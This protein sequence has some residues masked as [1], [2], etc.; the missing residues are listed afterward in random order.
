ML[1]KYLL[2]ATLNERFYNC[3]IINKNDKTKLSNLQKRYDLIAASD[4]KFS[5]KF[6]GFPSLLERNHF[7]QLLS[8]YLKAGNNAT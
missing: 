4:L 5:H 3:G 1:Q 2:V 8:R 6:S 7:W